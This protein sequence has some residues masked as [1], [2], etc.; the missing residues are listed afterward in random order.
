MVMTPRAGPRASQIR[1]LE[2]GPDPAP[3][4]GIRELGASPARPLLLW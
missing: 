3:D 4:V 2:E 1:G